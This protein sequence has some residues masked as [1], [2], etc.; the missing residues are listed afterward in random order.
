[1][2]LET[3]WNLKLFDFKDRIEEISEQAKQEAKM[4]TGIEK[5]VKF[6]EVIAFETIK[7]KDTS[8]YTLKMLDEN[9]E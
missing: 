8:V 4:G 7:H 6:W 9:F 2:E 3:I 5:V 1:M